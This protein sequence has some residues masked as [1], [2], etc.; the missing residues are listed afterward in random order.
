MGRHGPIPKRKAERRRENNGPG[1]KEKLYE[2]ARQLNVPGRS[3]MNRRQLEAAVRKEGVDPAAV[4]A[5]KS[6]GVGPVSAPGRPA[7]MPDPD[8][9]WHPIAARWFTSL[10]ESGQSAF[11]QAS[12]WMLAYVTAES[13][14]RE[15]FTGEPITGSSLTAYM[16]AM[17]ALMVSEGERRRVGVELS[18]PEPEPE[19]ES[20]VTSLA[21]FKARASGG[22]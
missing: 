19:A 14:S 3:K 10:G 2:A 17:A 1:P 11:Y 7:S 8:P 13:M 15:F 21:D 16:K 5:G 20:N 22:S 12:D 18:R 9:E 6:S 4:I